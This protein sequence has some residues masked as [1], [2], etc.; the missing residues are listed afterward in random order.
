MEYA[1]SLLAGG[2]AANLVASRR[3]LRDDLSERWQQVCQLFL[4]WLVPIVQSG[5][6][7]W[8]GGRIFS[9]PAST[10]CSR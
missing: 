5:N 1:L 6:S 4:V 7:Q 9:S 10:A 2:I 8:C 3:V